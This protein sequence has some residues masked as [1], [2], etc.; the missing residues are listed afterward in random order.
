MSGGLHARLHVPGRLDAELDADPGSVVA[1]IGPNGAGKTTLLTA[2]AGV[3][4][5]EGHVEVDGRSWTDPVVGVR[6]RRVGWVVQGQ[7]LFP[8]LSARDNV[9]F[10]LRARGVRRAEAA[11]RAQAW[12]D[13]LG[14]GEL[15]D[16]RPTRLSGGQ[17][18]RV[19]IAR[20]LV[21]EPRLL[22]LDEPFSGLDVGV[23]AAL[24]IELARHLASYDGVTLMVT[25]DALDALTLADR[26]VVLEDGRVA[27]QGTPGD[28]AARPRTDH[29]ARLVGLNVLRDDAGG[30]TAFRPQDVVVSP[31]EPDGSARLRWAGRVAGLTPHG[32][33]VRVQ[34]DTRAGA[35]VDLLADVTPAASAQLGLS[36]GAEVWVSVK[37]T[38]TRTYGGPG[39]H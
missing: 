29:V 3:V 6:E 34:V 33:A 25:H 8:H 5:A 35:G 4:A 30:F 16:R 27:Q 9:A 12:L 10:G 14:V 32:D 11:D 36:P 21:T 18:Q 24:R 23:A 37:A 15:A 7:A 39:A 28:V 19:T 26:V 17:A 13:R 1:V 22:L 38:A 2:L 20:A 31:T